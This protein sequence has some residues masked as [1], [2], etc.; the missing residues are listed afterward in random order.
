MRILL[1]TTLL[2]ISSCSVV[3]Q[4]RSTET[5]GELRVNCPEVLRTEGFYCKGDRAYSNLVQNGSR[6]RVVNLSTGKS[7]TIA[8]FRNE[9]IRGVCVP[10]SFR[11]LL[12]QE[13]F[14]ARLEIQRCG[15]DDKR[16]CPKVIRGLA[17]YYTDPYH[18]RETPYGIKYDM[19]GYYAAHK[20]LPL[21][22][23]L[24][25]KNLKNGRTVRVK[26]ID[27][28]PFKPERVLDLSYS[29]ARDLD[30]VKDGVVEVQ[31]IVLRCG[32]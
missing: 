26:V 17:S 23:L 6:V 9:N 20:E 30:M 32:D 3:I 21:G 14:P 16:T 11:R 18:G 13:P 22:T 7:I 31:A 24:E 2:F 28:G 12:G 29:A 4:D 19:Y 25:V 8:I 1:F 10:E 27:R 5:G 15:V